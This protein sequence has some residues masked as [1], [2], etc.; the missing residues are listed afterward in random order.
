MS[1][2]QNVGVRGV[3]RVLQR[4]RRDKK[5][6]QPDPL[7]ERV[8]PVLPQRTDLNVSLSD[9]ER[10]KFLDI[11]KDLQST[12]PLSEVYGALNA[13]NQLSSNKRRCS[14]SEEEEKEEEEVQGPCNATSL[15]EGRA[16][17][18][19]PK[20]KPGQVS[21]DDVAILVEGPFFG[22]ELQQ[23]KQ[24]R[25]TSYE[26][27]KKKMQERSGPGS[28]SVRGGNTPLLTYEK[29]FKVYYRVLNVIL[30]G[31]KLS[32]LV[33]RVQHET[34]QE[35]KDRLC[36]SSY[37][38]FQVFELPS[39]DM[40][41]SDM[42]SS[43]MSSS[44]KFAMALKPARLVSGK[45]GNNIPATFAKPVGRVKTAKTQEAQVFRLEDVLKYLES[46]LQKRTKD[47]EE[48]KVYLQPLTREL[49]NILKNLQDGKFKVVPALETSGT[50]NVTPS[51]PQGSPSPSE[52]VDFET[53]DPRAA[54]LAVQVL[55]IQAQ[56]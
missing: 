4:R 20:P 17:G 29:E 15:S 35:Q 42:S 40:S 34:A 46:V 25:K 30:K 28:P 10:K 6:K 23:K 26:R 14:C 52:G 50:A 21:T 56:K 33:Q 16:T 18:A 12:V 31:G 22:P 53:V 51:T 37:A 48:M 38:T 43:D 55:G 11:L 7:P 45:P 32:H 54:A 3:S 36:N 1:D 27:H 44:G 19:P 13:L 49:Y 24:A 47:E 2:A 5:R 39:S 8:D 9:G 41:S